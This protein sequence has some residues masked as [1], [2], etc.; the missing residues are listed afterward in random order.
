MARFTHLP[1][2][3]VLTMNLDVPEPW[4]VEQHEC[5]YDLG[6]HSAVF[7]PLIS[8]PLPSQTNRDT[9]SYI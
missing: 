9:H 4:L 6:P 2:K 8:F 5:T 1:K 3:H 7:L